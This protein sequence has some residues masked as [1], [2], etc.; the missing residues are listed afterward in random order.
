MLKSREIGCVKRFFWGLGCYI[1]ECN[2]LRMAA[3]W[4]QR[5]QETRETP[6]SPRNSP[7][8]N[9]SAITTWAPFHWHNA[10]V[11]LVVRRVQWN[12]PVPSLG[13]NQ[14]VQ[15]YMCLVPWL[16]GEKFGDCSQ[17]TFQYHLCRW[18]QVVKYI[19]IATSCVSPQSYI[20]F[21][22]SHGHNR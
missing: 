3:R 6:D 13:R 7:S 1:L 17:L 19:T 16:L 18:R 10:L 2:S 4:L 12:Q 5:P 9:S 20:F 11:G 14:R 15:N 22:R 8:L 21:G